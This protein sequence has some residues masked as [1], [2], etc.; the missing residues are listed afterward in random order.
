MKNSKFSLIQKFPSHFLKGIMEIEKKPE[1]HKV[2]SDKEITI[3]GGVWKFFMIKEF[4]GQAQ[5]YISYEISLAHQS[6]P[7][8]PDLINKGRTIYG[9]EFHK[10][11]IYEWNLD[12]M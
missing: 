2:K 10:C 7:D 12:G 6:S 4:Q 3:I 5:T 9:I 11:I 8:V 1:T